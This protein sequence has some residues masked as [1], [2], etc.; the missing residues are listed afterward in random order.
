MRLAGCYLETG[1]ESSGLLMYNQT[2]D[3]LIKTL[4]Y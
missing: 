4:M 2:N 1:N 3:V